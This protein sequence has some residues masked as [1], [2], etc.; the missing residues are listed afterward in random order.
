MMCILAAYLLSASFGLIFA[1]NPVQAQWKYWIPHTTIDKLP[2]YIVIGVA[3][4]LLDIVILSMPQTIVWKIHQSLKTRI[5][6]AA[7]FLLGG[8]CVSCLL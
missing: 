3:N 4:L 1:T 5:S 2:F 7:V 6:I 8:L